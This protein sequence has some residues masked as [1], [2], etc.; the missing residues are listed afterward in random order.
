[1][2]EEI[3]KSSEDGYEPTPKAII[4]ERIL[5][6]CSGHTK[7]IRWKATLNVATCTSTRV[8][9]KDIG[10]KYEKLQTEVIN[11]KEENVMLKSTILGF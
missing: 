2:Q 5:G 4:Y 1:M 3:R 9:E 11:L 6:K 7:G 10:D 8:F